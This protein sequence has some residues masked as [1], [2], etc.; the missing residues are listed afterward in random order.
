[1]CDDHLFSKR[2]PVPLR[3][4]QL[5][6]S[7]ATT[8][9]A[10]APGDPDIDHSSGPQSHTWPSLVSGQYLLPQSI[11]KVIGSMAGIPNPNYRYRGRSITRFPASRF[12]LPA[13]FAGGFLL[14]AP[15]ASA[16]YRFDSWTTDNGLPENS[17]NSIIQTSDGYLWLATFGGLVRYDGMN[18]RV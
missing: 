14:A 18:F 13:A 8:M 1:D 5:S 4:E 10:T 2:R 17:V 6:L 11:A 3:L 9:I 7:L 12:L 16:Q 15:A